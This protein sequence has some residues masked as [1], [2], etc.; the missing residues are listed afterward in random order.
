MRKIL[1]VTLGGSSEPIVRSILDHHPDKILF[2]VTTSP[3]GGSKKRLLEKVDNEESIITRTGLTE[4]EYEVH[5]ITSPDELVICHKQIKEAML[6]YTTVQEECNCIADYT[7]GTKTMAVALAT[8]ALDLNWKLSI[9]RG[10]RT[11]LVKAVDGT[12]IVRLVPTSPLLLERTLKRARSLFDLREYEAAESMLRSFLSEKNTAEN[13]VMRVQELLTL[14]RG[15]AAWDQFDH[16]RALD[17]LETRAKLVPNH[18][19]ALKELLG[20]SKGSGYE[21]VW[22]LINNAERR[23]S[24]GRYDDAVLRLY[25][26][27][28]MFAQVRL[29]TQYEISTSDIELE[30]LP[31]QAR[32]AFNWQLAQKRNRITAGFYDSYRM[33]SDLGDPIGPV[34][35]RW[36]DKIKNLL[37][38]RNRS[39]LAH[40][41]NPVGEGIWREASTLTHA[42]LKEIADAIGVRTA[43]PQFPTWQ[44]VKEGS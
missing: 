22:D 14:S 15:F 8:A 20:E 38:K 1:A 11:N 33:L 16:K 19:R 30:K 9:V 27:L 26:A 5:E 3:N 21:K 32:T 31:A 40:G 18:V 35:R 23:A 12:E 25:R 4:S 29:R 42:F 34:Y 6:R 17:L 10:E 2:F 41:D 7:G 43:W 36:K 13:E 37:D 44:E 24:Q 39:I 28:E